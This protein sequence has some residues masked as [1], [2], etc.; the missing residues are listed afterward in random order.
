MAGIFTAPIATNR[1]LAAQGIDAYSTTIGDVVDAAAEEAWVRNP[2]PSLGR[3]LERQSHNEGSIYAALNQTRT[4]SADEATA[5]YGIEGHLS[6]DADIPEP[7]AAEL[8]QLKQAELYRQ[9]ILAR[10]PTGLARG[11]AELGTGFL[12]S[13]VDPLNI[14][15]AFVPVVGPARY[16][17]WLQRAGSGLGRAGVRMGVGAIEGAAGAAM[18]EPLV[19]GAARAEQADYDSTDSLLNLAFG[20]ALG[21]G[22]HVGAGAVG[23]RWAAFKGRDPSY[24]G[25]VDAE[26]RR[27]L[28]GDMTKPDGYVTDSLEAFG[29]MRPDASQLERALAAAR[30]ETREAM[31]RAA[32]AHVADDR[33]VAIRT[34][35]R[36]DPALRGEM[37]DVGRVLEAAEDDPLGPMDAALA[38]ISPDGMEAILFQKGEAF[39][40]GQGE[41]VAEGDFFKARMPVDASRG[42]VK[43]LV[44][45]GEFSDKADAPD[46]LT[47]ADIMALPDIVRSFAPVPGGTKSWGT[48][49]VMELRWEVRRADG[50]HVRYIVNRGETGELL[51]ASVHVR[52]NGKEGPL[53]ARRAAP[54]ASTAGSNAR[55]TAGGIA[56]RPPEA[57]G[58]TNQSYTRRPPRGQA[59][60]GLSPHVPQAVF[61]AAGR[62]LMVRYQV[63]EADDL[64]PSHTDDLQVNPAFPA[65]LQ[66][67]ERGRA[68]AE[69]QIHDIVAKF[70]PELLGVSPDAAT[71]APILAK[72]DNVVESGNGRVLAIRRVY[73]K[74]GDAE[75][76]Y[77]AFLQRLG[78]DTRAHRQPV[79]VRRRLDDLTADERRAFTVAAQKPATLDLSATERAKADAPLLDN[80]LHLLGDADGRIGD[81]AL[82]RNARF[83]RAFVDAQP[84]ADQGRMLDSDGNLSRDGRRR[85]EAAL[86]ARAYDDSDL[87]GRMLESDDDNSRAVIGALL[88]IAPD[89]AAMRAAA[90]KGDINPAVDATGELVAAVRAVR[91]ARATGR[92]L[93]EIR[94]QADM[95]AAPSPTTDRFLG[96][97]LRDGGDGR[98]RT[99]SRE[100]IG[101]DLARYVDQA[102]RSNPAPDM[103]GTKPPGPD[104]LL[105]LLGR[106]IP[107]GVPADAD[108]LAALRAIDALLAEQKRIDGPDDSGL[109]AEIDGLVAE[110][111]VDAADP[112]LAAI[113]A[114]LD[115]GEA[116]TRALDAAATCLIRG[117]P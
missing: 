65:E 6:F 74:G 93:A 54:L 7:V 103:F 114:A 76:A 105:D 89:W 16:A 82:A 88:D 64:V 115:D 83:V 62:R 94:A 111:L 90:A 14:A 70:E 78:F 112:E 110:G 25:T 84:Q 61:D 73:A 31:L 55:D 17:L 109:D 91:D 97:L 116:E 11:A 66:P 27:R 75:D 60:G 72:D 41:I 44:K 81:I 2:L 69:A 47:R 56:H 9:S 48:D 29:M 45:H 21:G 1:R 104:E 63:V 20:T 30:P 95:F 19:Y 32:I 36:M 42:A 52:K 50:R 107:E 106:D 35:A 33:P 101:Q 77:R 87:L 68:A 46:M 39:L 43:L 24:T 102:M 23:D 3:W 85:I 51:T 71:G 99:A 49:R 10:G 40:D 15:S 79:L 53:S 80:I 117:A 12:V 98:V 26:A 5:R 92:P 8:Q 18:L 13:A 57:S 113:R 22:L 86:L 59:R 100:A 28:A 37:L 96:V 4:L 38:R 108:D 34:L 67:R 58:A